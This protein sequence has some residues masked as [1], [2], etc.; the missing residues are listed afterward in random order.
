[1]ALLWRGSHDGF[2]AGAF[3]H[4]CDGRVPTLALIRDARRG[5]FWRFAPV[6]WDSRWGSRW[7]PCFKVDPSLASFVF[8]YRRGYAGFV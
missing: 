4:L 6:R 5:V 1:L 7:S 3:H 8:S 2:R